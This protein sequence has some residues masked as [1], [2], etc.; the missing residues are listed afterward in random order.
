MFLHDKQAKQGA[1]L[2]AEVLVKE[3]AAHSVVGAI[4]VVAI[5]VATAHGRHGSAWCSID[6]PGRAGDRVDT[7]GVRSRAVAVIPRL[8]RI[9]VPPAAPLRR[10]TDDAY[11]EGLVSHGYAFSKVG[12]ARVGRIAWRCIRGVAKRRAASAA[13]TRVQH[14]IVEAGK[15]VAATTGNGAGVPLLS[16]PGRKALECLCIRLVVAAFALLAVLLKRMAFAVTVEV[17]V[18]VAVAVAV[19]RCL[20]RPHAAEQLTNLATNAVR[21]IA[22]ELHA[23]VIEAWSSDAGAGGVAPPACPRNTDMGGYRVVEIED[24]IAGS[25]V[26]GSVVP[27]WSPQPARLVGIT[28]VWH[29]DLGLGFVGATYSSDRGD[30]GCGHDDGLHVGIVLR[31]ADLVNPSRRTAVRWP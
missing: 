27:A 28:E 13:I 6:E 24:F 4:P 29:A 15:A 17:A 22:A 18:A 30:D 8:H 16:Y 3:R 19:S 10:L 5:G 21:D 9:I 20:G 11:P 7:V 26:A 14:N 25:T 23:W 12:R 31:A 1:A 2:D